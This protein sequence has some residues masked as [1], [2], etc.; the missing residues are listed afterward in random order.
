MTQLHGD[1]LI[2]K[3][4]PCIDLNGKTG[5]SL[6][7]TA[8]DMVTSTTPAKAAASHLPG[9]ALHSSEQKQ[10]KLESRGLDKEN[11]TIEKLDPACETP[12]KAISELL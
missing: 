11:Q 4:V 10:G 3:V 8:A 6:S 9:A 2:T 1:F 5:L 7:N 12:H